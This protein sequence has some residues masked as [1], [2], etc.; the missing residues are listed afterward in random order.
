MLAIAANMLGK[1]LAYQ[2]QRS[3]TPT[4]A[5]EI[6]IQNI[7]EGNRQAI[8]EVTNSKGRA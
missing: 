1:L 7:E 3:M 6:I 5:M 8:A 4:A 2:D